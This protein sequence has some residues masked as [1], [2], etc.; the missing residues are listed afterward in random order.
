MSLRG[1]LRSTPPADEDLQ[2][3][4]FAKRQKLG[5]KVDM[6]TMIVP[7]AAALVALELSMSSLTGATV[8]RWSFVLFGEA[9]V[10]QAAE[11]AAKDMEFAPESNSC[12]DV[13]SLVHD[14]GHRPNSSRPKPPKKMS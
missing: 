6:H 1:P 12:R 3:E 8:Q 2:F 13:R 10:R 5:L 11:I 14:Q 9:T 4:L 7:K